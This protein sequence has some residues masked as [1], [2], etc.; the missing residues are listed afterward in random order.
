[1]NQ[2]GHQCTNDRADDRR[3]DRE[4]RPVQ[5]AAHR[6]HRRRR[7]RARALDPVR[8]RCQVKMLQ[9]VDDDAAADP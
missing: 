9:P 6:R 8:D 7:M 1:M 5:R 4:D 2:D 3:S